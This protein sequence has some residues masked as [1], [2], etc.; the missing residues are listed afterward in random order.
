MSMVGNK[1]RRE[2][3]NGVD[4]DSNTYITYGNLAGNIKKGLKISNN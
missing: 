4:H 1:I 2:R 3:S